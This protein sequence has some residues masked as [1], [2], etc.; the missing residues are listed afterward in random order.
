MADR[1]LP[2]LLKKLHRLE[3]EYADGAGYD[4][5]P[6]A[7]FMSESETRDWIRAWTGNPAL[8][9]AEFLVFGHDGTGGHAA[10]WRVRPTSSLV[11]QPV[12]FLGSEGDA[13]VVARN[14]AEYVWLLAG[15]VGPCEAVEQPH[16]PPASKRIRADFRRFAEEHAKDS[17][18]TPAEV[19]R[20]AAQEFPEFNA[21]IEAIC[22]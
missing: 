22:R 19:L 13:G 14:L 9:G 7:E 11:E 10:F 4:F 5:E 21:R 17:Q 12:V 20:A 16:R 8:D 15:G 3:F 18:R 1:S 2:E 6:Y